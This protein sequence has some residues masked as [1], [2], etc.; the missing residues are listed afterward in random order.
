[1]VLYQKLTSHNY[2]NRAFELPAAEGNDPTYY[3]GN[4]E[5]VPS[6]WL[7]KNVGLG[8]FPSQA[9]KEPRDKYTSFQQ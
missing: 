4:C 2:I 1:M 8:L 7:L 6:G 9:V 3:N 5:M